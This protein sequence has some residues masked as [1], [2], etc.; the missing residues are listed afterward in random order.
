[1]GEWLQGGPG[2]NTMLRLIISRRWL[3][4][5]LLVI[6]A[7]A[8]MARLGI[9]QLD[10][11][12]QRRQF[13]ARVQA[14]IDQPPLELTGPALDANLY[15]MEYREVV[16]RG[17]YDHSQEVAIRNQAYNQQWGVFLVTPL[18]IEGSDRA[19]LV[20]RGWI[21][22]ED[23]Q[24]GNW[25][26]YAEPGVVTVRGVLR[27]S[28][29]QPD[30]GPRRDPTPVP[31]GDAVKAWHFV[32]VE[33]LDRQISYDLLPVYVHQA[34]DPAW[35]GMPVRAELNVELSE[36]SHLGY[37]IQWFAFAALLGIGYPFFVR[38]Q[39][40]GDG[41]R[42]DEENDENQWEIPA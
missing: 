12:E 39:A 19:V 2:K 41:L 42:I 38:K 23:Y 8:V 31:G 30:F 3:L 7:V 37:A 6:A 4:T 13:N 27:R 22:A 34:S 40:M 16:V 25:E 11:L 33:W 21:P 17:R 29:S 20:N 1:M 36:G 15:D 35:T 32:H 5:T 9:W 10:R 26:K 14:Q 28:Q 24:S 18:R